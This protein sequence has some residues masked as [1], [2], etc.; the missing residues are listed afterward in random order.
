MEESQ[1]DKTKKLMGG[2]AVSNGHSS[3]S[4]SWNLG[5]EDRNILGTGTKTV[6]RY[7]SDTYE[8]IFQFGLSN[9]YITQD[10]IELYLDY[11]RI[12]RSATSDEH[13]H[14][15]LVANNR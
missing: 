8:N 13:L 12:L 9:P 6:L 3:L 5:Y 2:V 15:L 4:G 1:E 14:H 11:E 10:N 7:E